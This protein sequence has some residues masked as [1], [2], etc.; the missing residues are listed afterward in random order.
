MKEIIINEI[1]IKKHL[2]KRKAKKQKREKK[3]IKF[4]LELFSS[5]RNLFL[6]NSKQ[7]QTTKFQSWI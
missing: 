1:E 6:I 5:Y 3:R 2:K 7:I 4:A